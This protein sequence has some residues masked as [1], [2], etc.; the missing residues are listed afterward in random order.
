MSPRWDRAAATPRGS[1]GW[2][3]PG[4]RQLISRGSTDPPGSTSVRSAQARSRFRSPRRWSGA[5]ML[6]SEQVALVLLAAGRS[7][8][9]EDGDKLT[10]LFLDKPLAFHVVTALENMPF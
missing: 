8:R 10:E 1:S 3:P 6:K 4:L 2:R 7:R 9:F 5:S